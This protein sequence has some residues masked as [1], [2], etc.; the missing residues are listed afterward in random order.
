M[1]QPLLQIIVGSTRP[2][3]RGGAVGDWFHDLAVRHDRFDIELVDLF[4]VDLPM[5]DE[6]RPSGRRPYTK[7]HTQAWSRIELRAVVKEAF[8]A[9]RGGQPAVLSV[10]LPRA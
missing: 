8:T 5:L 3:R 4:D 1:A 2:G 6:P 10:H 9:V 7:P